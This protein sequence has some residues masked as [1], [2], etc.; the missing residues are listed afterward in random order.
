M[1][2]STKKI[3]HV[4]YISGSSSLQSGADLRMFET[5]EYFNQ[6][7]N[8]KCSIALSGKTDQDSFRNITKIP[9]YFLSLER[10]HRPLR[11]FNL[12]SYF[13]KSIISFISLCIL[14]KKQNINIVHVN[15]ILDLSGLLAG[16]LMKKKT[17]CHVRVILTKPHFIKKLLT[18]LSL[19]LSDEIICV[20]KATKE[21]MFSDKDN[22]KIK[23]I[24]DSGPDLNKFKPGI[25]NINLLEEFLLPKKSFVV[26]SVSK[27]TKHKGQFILIKA[28][29]LIKKRGIKNIKYLFIGG[30]VLGHEKYFT[31]IKNLI[32]KY[33]LQEDFIFTGYRQDIPSLMNLCD[34][35]IHVPIHHDPFPGVVLEAMVMKK[36]IIASRSGGIEEQIQDKNTGFLIKRGDYK[37]LS[38]NIIHLKQNS[39]LRK[40]IGKKAEQSVKSRFSFQKYFDNIKNIYETI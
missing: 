7:D 27:F 5:A 18:K 36:A 26:G 3:T 1:H 22:P 14:I 37:T 4:L 2:K 24:Y 40:V 20:S 34:I 19:L 16:K 12:I 25:K 11:F 32:K 8:Y 17:I 29:Q 23:I 9:L 30:K 15:E 21:K 10:V 28:A 13:F 38:R 33:N 6:K 35:L 39:K 31:Q